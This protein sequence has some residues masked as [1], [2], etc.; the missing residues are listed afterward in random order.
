MDSGLEIIILGGA[1]LLGST[2]AGVTGFG[3]AAILLPILIHF[4]GVK[5]AIPILTVAQLIGNGS[6]VYFFRR[7]LDLKVVSYFALG[8]VPM[9]L[10]GGYVF[11]RSTAPQLVR[12]VGVF[13]ILSVG[14]RRLR[15]SPVR[16][17]PVQ[18]FT[19]LGALFSFLSALVGSVGPLMVPFFLAY[20]LA[21]GAFIAT[22][23]LAT[24]VMHV[25]KIVA[26]QQ[27]NYLS[28]KSVL[29]GMGMGSVMILGSWIGTRLLHRMPERAFFVLVEITLLITGVV[30]IFRD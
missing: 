15:R 14:W 24:I 5:E 30:F 10:V 20:G 11:A 19:P 27:T 8:A 6:R 7:K 21:G 3:G 25:F 2:L 1:A 9:A 13:L 17:F 26:Y 12:I 22:E 4:F 23:A 28:L 16:S 29:I 18:L